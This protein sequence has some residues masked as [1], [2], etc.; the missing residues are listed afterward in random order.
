MPN[1]P[2]SVCRVRDAAAASGARIRKPGCESL[3]SLGAMK[4]SALWMTPAAMAGAARVPP[5][6]HKTCAGRPESARPLSAEAL[7]SLRSV[8]A[9]ASL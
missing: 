3:T 6:S 9:V 8:Q 5:H 7:S 1:N 2:K 4:A